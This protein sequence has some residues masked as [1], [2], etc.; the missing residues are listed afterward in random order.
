MYP[1]WL[2]HITDEVIAAIIFHK[3]VAETTDN[4]PAVED[5]YEVDESKRIQ[6]QAILDTMSDGI[7]VIFYSNDHTQP[8]LRFFNNALQ[9]LLDDMTE[10]SRPYQ[11]VHMNRSLQDEIPEAAQTDGFWYQK[12]SY[13]RLDGATLECAMT[14][15]NM[16]NADGSSMGA[17]VV[18]HDA[19]VDEDESTP[20]FQIAARIAHE[21]RTPITNLKTRLY[22]ARKKPEAID[23]HLQILERVV[24][25]MAGIIDDL[26]QISRLERNLVKLNREDTT[27][28]QLL[29]SALEIQQAEADKNQIKFET[30]LPTN[31]LPISVDIGRMIQV[32]NNLSVNAIN[33]TP[34]GGTIIIRAVREQL[35][36][37]NILIQIRDT[38]KGIAPEH[39]PHIFEPFYQGEVHQKGLGLGLSIVQE[40][41]ELHGGSITVDSVP[42]NGACF[43]I[44]L[45]SAQTNQSYEQ[46]SSN[47][48]GSRA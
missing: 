22:L 15:R 18:I 34:R 43:N 6:L 41:I 27:I 30:D 39:L 23:T 32:I 31:P 11:L 35:D 45:K 2:S 10:E 48:G 9:N 13:K 25:H 44:R 19:S 33:H 20:Q 46:S 12:E 36:P 3:Q 17:V 40:I 7:A 24:D 5:G 21:L 38:G 28:Q 26:M 4:I 29:S 42:G 16:L 8:P 14:I 37:D 47:C 1:N